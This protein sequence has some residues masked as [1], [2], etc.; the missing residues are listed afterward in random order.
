LKPLWEAIFRTREAEDLDLA[1]FLASEDNASIFERR[2]DNAKLRVPMPEL[3]QKV[4]PFSF[5]E[6]EGR[7]EIQ[8]PQMREQE[9]AACVQQFF[10]QDLQKK[11]APSKGV[12]PF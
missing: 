10:R 5:R 6:R 7:E 9:G 3:P 4:F 12:L 11:L 1:S 2:P 8:V